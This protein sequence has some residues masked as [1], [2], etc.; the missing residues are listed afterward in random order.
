MSFK[1]REEYLSD[2][3]EFCFQNNIKT[4]NSNLLNFCVLGNP[5][6]IVLVEN[7][8]DKLEEERM[9]YRKQKSF[10]YRIFN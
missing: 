5:K 10:L 6:Q 2:V 3:Y 1:V 8:I 4:K 7:Y 9:K